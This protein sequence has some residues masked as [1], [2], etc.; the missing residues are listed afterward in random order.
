MKFTRV[1]WFILV[2]LTFS[3]VPAFAAATTFTQRFKSEVIP[4]IDP[5]N[6]CNPGFGFGIAN[7]VLHL[8]IAGND[9]VHLALTLTG[10]FEV[11]DT[12]SGQNATGRFTFRTGQQVNITGSGQIRQSETTVLSVNG[13]LEDGSSI[14]FNLLFRIQLVDGT[15]TLEFTNVVCR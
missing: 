7:G 1:F 2:L 3:V 6:P 4:I 14:G 5:E 13:I 10:P 12:N 8:T 9:S 15:P 11:V